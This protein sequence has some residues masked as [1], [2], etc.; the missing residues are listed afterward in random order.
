MNN[1][2]TAPLRQADLHSAVFDHSAD[3]IEVVSESTHCQTQH[4]NL[5]LC[6]LGSEDKYTLHSSHW[7]NVC[8]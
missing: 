5:L 8:F 6:P 1:R 2:C 4:L 3:V 7:D